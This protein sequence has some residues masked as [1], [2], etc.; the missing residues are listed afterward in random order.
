MALD[1]VG[2]KEK[3]YVICSGRVTSRTEGASVPSFLQGCG[4]MRLKNSNTAAAGH[5]DSLHVGRVNLCCRGKLIPTLL[6]ELKR[7]IQ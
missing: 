6:Q 2:A 3:P 7:P 1:V 5:P 4:T